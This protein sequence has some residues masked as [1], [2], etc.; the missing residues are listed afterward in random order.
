VLDWPVIVLEPP[1]PE[2]SATQ[3]KAIVENLTMSVILARPL[4]TGAF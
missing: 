3:I 4:W 2:S 1:Q